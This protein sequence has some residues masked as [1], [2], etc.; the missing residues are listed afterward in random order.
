MEKSKKYLV[1]LP[2][3]VR[4]IHCKADVIDGELICAHDI[5][6]YFNNG[7]CA[8]RQLLDE[9]KSRGLKARILMRDDEVSRMIAEEN[10]DVVLGL[11]CRPKVKEVSDALVGQNIGCFS[12]ELDTKECFK[13]TDK[14]SSYD[15]DS[16]KRL[17]DL[18]KGGQDENK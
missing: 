1:L 4:D 18:A 5:C 8:M 10:P 14:P 17:L 11:A 13:K 7:K 16:Y 12:A 3:C 15:L 2:Y 9:A 6:D